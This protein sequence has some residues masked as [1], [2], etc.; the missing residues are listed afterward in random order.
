MSVGEGRREAGRGAVCVWRGGDQGR[1]YCPEENGVK[2]KSTQ[3]CHGCHRCCCC[4]AVYGGDDLTQT[5]GVFL[6]SAFGLGYNF[7]PLNQVCCVC[8]CVFG[9]A[10]VARVML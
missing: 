8:V 3:R 4:Y 6:D 1:R 10:N 9:C 2:Q 7:R 5:N